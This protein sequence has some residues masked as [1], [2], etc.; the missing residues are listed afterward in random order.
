MTA[1]QRLARRLDELAHCTDAPPRLTR[2]A[3]SPAMRRAHDL[4][5]DWMREAGLTV[6]V[7]A[8]G[9]LVGHREGTTP[10]AK[11][12]LLGSHLD[13]V[14]NAG[15]FDGPLGVLLAIACAEERPTL[16][17]A[18]EVLG[19]ID[20]EGV[21]FQS[22][23]LGSRALAGTLPPEA[24]AITDADGVSLREAIRQFGCDPSALPTERREPDTLIG[25]VEAHIEQ[26]P[27]LEARHQPLG[28]VS[29]I[30]GQT[31]VA[32]TFTG[33]A[34]HAGTVP[35]SLRK[36]ALCA[37]AEFIIAAQKTAEEIEGLVA[38]VG[39][40]TIPGAASNVI[41]GRV[42][43]TLD[44][45]HPSDSVRR[46]Q[47]QRL[48]ECARTGTGFAVDWQ[49]VQETNAV[50]CDHTLSK[51]LAEAVGPDAIVLPSGAGHDAAALAA[52]CPVAM[53]F[54]RC[55]GGVSHH[56]DEFASEEDLGA[57]LAALV[58]FLDLLTACHA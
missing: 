56:P 6:R 17:F 58:R 16:P 24:L 7:D 20:E 54:V 57:A 5:G 23:Y 43:L 8:V 21:R 4:V 46:E 30:A 33:E 50:V 22:T 3:Y 41:P 31:R 51:K 27:V 14:R 29:A 9:N 28:V 11:T 39:Q 44:V 36:D 25:Y 18:I 32:I 49:V 42:A 26:G 45:R 48:E 38:T 10:G 34:G 52:L 35:M 19:F 15:R 12:L 40:L 1:A 55:R 37:A 53:L 47:V 2:L 13:S